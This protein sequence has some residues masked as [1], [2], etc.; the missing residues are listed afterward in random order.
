[1]TV[2]VLVGTGVDVIDVDVHVVDEQVEVVAVDAADVEPEERGH[3][4]AAHGR[5]GSVT[6][7][8]V[9]EDNLPIR[10]LNSCTAFIKL[11]FKVNKNPAK[12]PYLEGHFVFAV[13]V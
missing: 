4:D 13:I 9:S 10:L 6:L 1:M 8:S 12:K 5:G 2:V 11:D 7:D 3:D